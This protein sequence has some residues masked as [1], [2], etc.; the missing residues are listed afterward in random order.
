[1]FEKQP[2]SVSEYTIAHVNGNDILYSENLQKAMILNTTSAF[3]WDEVCKIHTQNRFID[4]SE[5]QERVIG[6]FDISNIDDN[7]VL[8][9]IHKTIQQ[10]FNEGFLNLEI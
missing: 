6:E 5:I 3:I 9:D 1:M 8:E 10:F 4:Y 7:I 2:F